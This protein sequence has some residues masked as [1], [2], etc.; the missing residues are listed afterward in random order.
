[1]MCTALIGRTRHATRGSLDVT[2][3]GGMGGQTLG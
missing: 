3:L 1:M 2:M